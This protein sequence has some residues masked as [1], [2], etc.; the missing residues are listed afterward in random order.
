LK[1]RLDAVWTVPQASLYGGFIRGAACVGSTGS[2]FLVDGVD[3][4]ASAPFC[5]PR[6]VR[7]DQQ[8]KQA[9]QNEYLHIVLL[10]FADRKVS[11]TAHD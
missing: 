2:I 3:A 11:R 9:N 6:R 4:F 8:A 10:S 7:R 1:G 5:R